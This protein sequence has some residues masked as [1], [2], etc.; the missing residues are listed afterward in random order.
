MKFNIITLGCPKNEVDS[1]GME[2]LL[3]E[4]GH[5]P[6]D[7]FS[8]ADLVVV[9][10]CG[11]I[12]A[13]RAEALDTLREVAAGKGA[14]TYLVAAGCLAQR[15]G[16]AL[17]DQVAGIDAVLGCRN[18]TDI[19]KVAEIL[20]RQKGSEEQGGAG[21]ASRCGGRRAQHDGIDAQDGT[22]AML[23]RNGVPA[24]VGDELCLGDVR[25]SPKGAS[26][27]LKISDG[28]DAS[29]SFCVIPSIKGG[30]KSKPLKQ[31][32][33]EARSLVESGVQEIILVGRIPQLTDWTGGARWLAK[34]FV[35]Y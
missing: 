16:E 2:V 26:A 12:D 30:L 5:C 17:I 29:C 20:Q 34:L 9:N 33:A 21:P 28:C 35:V 10:T 27:Y 4:A 6:V 14:G 23:P 7:D 32:L 15:E 25:R 8:N 18:W 22:V 13:A 11:F 24:F 31:V 3:T 1:E 19:T